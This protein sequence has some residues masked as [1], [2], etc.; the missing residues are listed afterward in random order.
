MPRAYTFDVLE[1]LE[2]SM[3]E[4]GLNVLFIMRAYEDEGW[5]IRASAEYL[6][7]SGWQGISIDG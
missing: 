5:K 2:M 4:V 7:V 6:L 1:L 3:F